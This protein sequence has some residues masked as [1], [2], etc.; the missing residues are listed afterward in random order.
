[1]KT[2]NVKIAAVATVAVV[3]CLAFSYTVYN[4]EDGPSPTWTYS[5]LVGGLPDTV[6]D[7]ADDFYLSTNYD[8]ISQH[9]DTAMTDSAFYSMSQN[10]SKLVNGADPSDPNAAVFADFQRLFLDTSVRDSITTDDLMPYL[11]DLMAAED[12]D[13][14]TAYLTGGSCVLSNPFLQ[15]TLVGMEHVTPV[16][17]VYVI[18]AQF[19]MSAA[20]YAAGGYEGD[21]EEAETFYSGVMQL[22]GYTAEQADAMNDAA[23]AVELEILAGSSATVVSSMVDIYDPVSADELSGHSFPIADIL[24]SMGYH[25]DSYVL[26]DPGWLDTM[27]S[28]Y[29]EEN[30]EGLRTMILRNSLVTA[31][32]F[33]GGEFFDLYSGFTGQDVRTLMSAIFNGNPQVM[34]LIN[35]V[36]SDACADE[37]AARVVTGLFYDLK[38]VFADHIRASD[39]MDDE[40]KEA[41]LQKL[42]AML[43]KVGGPDVVDYSGIAGTVDDPLSLYLAISSVYNAYNASAAGEPIE[44]GYWAMQ[45]FTVNAQHVWSMNTVYVSWAFLQEGYYYNE[46]ADRESQL[47]TLGFVIGHEITHGFDTVGRHYAADGSTENWWSDSSAAAF[48]EKADDV[49]DYISRV[50][51]L[52]DRTLDADTVIGEVIADMGGMSLILDIAEN[53]GLDTARMIRDYAEMWE[54]VRTEAFD[55]AVMADEH[56]PDCARVNMTLQQFQVFHDLFGVT[57]G[58]GMY[59]APEDRVAIW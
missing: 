48:S 28:V 19:T 35:T 26:S 12:L 14:L 3:L 37:E 4:G 24:E 23:T 8:W 34:S 46:G 49:A 18:P 38:D 55:Q 15:T 21:M 29:T 45:S 11:G 39:W 52:P 41:A 27:D 25:A 32:Q 40:T 57:E 22:M 51:L 9:Q 17:V 30:F 50:T 10:V 20:E 7:A 44:S 43:I 1:M 53:E 58:D 42:D 16:Y 33:M 56:P 5:N 59:L 31:S 2:G 54:S 47:A 13:D 6:P 36:Y